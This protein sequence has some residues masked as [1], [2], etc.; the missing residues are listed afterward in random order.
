[1]RSLFLVNDR[2]GKRGR[3]DVR[4]LIARSPLG[5]AEIVACT[6]K[7]A[8]DAI[9]DH[10]EGEGID[11]VF[12]VGGDGTVHETAKRL[13][14]RRPALGI[15][16][17][18][19]GNGFARHIG[20]PMNAEAA[21]AACAAGEIVTVD[22][23]TVAGEPFVGVMGLGFDALIAERFASSTSR[24]LA[25]YVREGVAALTSRRAGSY[26]LTFNGRTLHV[27][28]A[29]VAVA[30]SA[31]YGNEARI[32]PRASLSDG[33]LD[34]VIVSDRS[35]FAI[36]SLLMRLFSGTIDAADG[37]TTFQTE[38]VT[39]RREREGAAHLDGEPF[40]LPAE[41]EV[42]IRPRT[43]RLLVPGTNARL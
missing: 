25:S 8:L 34:L 28:A 23:A 16:P 18:G 22:S 7:E 40:Q 15:I 38:A 12:A 35:L 26:E 36:P 43:L 41:L 19:S 27:E 21:L 17:T 11:V 14:G 32:A 13:I 5:S 37:V 9:I 4:D 31:Q 6:S 29:V 24:G 10:A 2:S 33:L 30:N 42:Q 20:V 39:I 3:G 1:M